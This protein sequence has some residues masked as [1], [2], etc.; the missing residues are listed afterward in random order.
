V[1][2]CGFGSDV[3]AMFVVTPRT[4][5]RMRT[6][7]NQIGKADGQQKIIITGLDRGQH[8]Q[9]KGEIHIAYQSRLKCASAPS[10]GV[11]TVLMHKFVYEIES[12]S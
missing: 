2:K 10:S 5:I 6:Y 4:C 3:V 1:R 12:T 7:C 11:H 9:C 8:Q